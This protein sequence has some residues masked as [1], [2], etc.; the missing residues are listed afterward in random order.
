MRY[1]M[2]NP[3]MM[4]PTA[5]KTYPKYRTSLLEYSSAG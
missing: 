4:L 5:K 1:L 2:E 3:Q